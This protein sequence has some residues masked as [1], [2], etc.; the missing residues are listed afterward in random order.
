MAWFVSVQGIIQTLSATGILTPI[1][2]YENY[3]KHNYVSSH[4]V[5]LGDK[6]YGM[7]YVINVDTRVKVSENLYESGGDCLTYIVTKK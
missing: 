2:A 7:E 3:S 1:R 6:K 5:S 4:L